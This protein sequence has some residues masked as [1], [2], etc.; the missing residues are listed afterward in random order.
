MLARR[1]KPTPLLMRPASVR[2]AGSHW[3]DHPSLRALSLAIGM[4]SLSI[5]CS[6]RKRTSARMARAAPKLPL[7]VMLAAAMVWPKSRLRGRRIAGGRC[8]GPVV[9]AGLP[10]SAGWMKSCAVTVVGPS[11][12]TASAMASAICSGGSCVLHHGASIVDMGG[13]G[14]PVSSGCSAGGSGK[15]CCS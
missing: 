4:W 11:A 2:M 15:G 3:L 8:G 5:L 9:G 1:V 7:E 6:V 10:A 12:L 13:I 14:G